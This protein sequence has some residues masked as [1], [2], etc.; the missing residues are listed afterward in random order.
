MSDMETGLEIASAY[1]REQAGWRALRAEIARLTAELAAEREKSATAER[2]RAEMA[3]ALERAQ[4]H[5]S[6][7]ET[8]RGGICDCGQPIIVDDPSAILTAHNAEQRRAGAVAGLKAMAE[9]FS[10]YA[11]GGD[12]AV[13]KAIRMCKDFADAIERGEVEP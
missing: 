6:W 1:E 10:E 5:A 13:T 3:A 7:C 12:P 9:N 8:H 4:E 2:Q 11:I